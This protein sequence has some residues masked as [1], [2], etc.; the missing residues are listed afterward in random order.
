[1]RRERALALH[2]PRA[3][4]QEVARSSG[5]R[6]GPWHFLPHPPFSISDRCPQF[7]VHSSEKR[8]QDPGAPIL[9]PALTYLSERCL[10]AHAYPFCRGLSRELWAVWSA[11]SGHWLCSVRAPPNCWGLGREGA[12]SGALAPVGSVAGTLLEICTGP[13]TF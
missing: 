3:P 12:G 13:I 1:M 5:H 9:Y 10:P 8:S 11:Q 6:A 4:H 2:Q 7:S